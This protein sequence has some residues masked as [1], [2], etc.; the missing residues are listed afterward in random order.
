MRTI[1]EGLF[2]K[3]LPDEGMILTDVATETMR[4]GEID[5]GKS[6]SADNYK[7]IPIPDLTVDD[8]LQMLN[9]LGVDTN[10]Q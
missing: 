7:D 2:I 3:L 10:D 6:D 9:Q 5:L 8:T 4:T 1:D